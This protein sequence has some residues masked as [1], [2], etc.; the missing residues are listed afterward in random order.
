MQNMFKVGVFI[1][2][3]EHVTTDWVVASFLILNLILIFF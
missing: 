3:F 1:A 2:N